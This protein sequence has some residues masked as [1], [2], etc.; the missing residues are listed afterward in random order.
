MLGLTACGADVERTEAAGV[1]DAF[2]A[3]EVTDPSAACG[4]LAPRALEA[5]EEDGADCPVALAD[6]GLPEAG[7]RV[8]VVVAGHSAQ[9]RY[10]G[11][12]VFL[13]RFD[14]GWRVTAAGC[15]R[16]ST[17]PAVPYDCAVDGS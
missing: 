9:V 2:E 13:A 5:V 11:D 3:A 7:A 15:R 12:T 1:A 14:D 17:D 4:R 10:S 6:V 16:V 8:S